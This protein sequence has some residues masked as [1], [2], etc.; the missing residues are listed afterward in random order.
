MFWC[1]I[2][3]LITVASDAEQT[4]NVAIVGFLGA[5]LVFTTS[6]VNSLVYSASPAKEAAA[7]G[8]ILLSMVAVCF[9]SA[10][11]FDKD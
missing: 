6:S 5:G 7:A 3:V 10:P 4:Y 11:D 8:F 9:D 1:I 2:G